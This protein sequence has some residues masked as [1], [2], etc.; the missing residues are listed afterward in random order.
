MTSAVLNELAAETC[1]AAD[2]AKLNL[3]NEL[4]PLVRFQGVVELDGENI[5]GDQV[6]VIL[7]RRRIGMIFHRSKHAPDAQPPALLAH[8]PSE[9][10]MSLR[11]RRRR[12]PRRSA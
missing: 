10:I 12:G 3:M 1:V 2:P 6:D 7:S 4:I 5:Y 11:T 9:L 8:M